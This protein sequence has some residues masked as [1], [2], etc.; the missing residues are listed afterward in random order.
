MALLAFGVLRLCPPLCAFVL[1]SVLLVAALSAQVA[2]RP[3]E[4]GVYV[5]LDDHNDAAQ[6]RID[7][8]QQARQTI[9]IEYFIAEA[10]RISLG[11]LVLL[12]DAAR[13]GVRVRILLD[14]S[15][16]RL[17]RRLQGYMV[18]QGIEI[19]EYHPFR[20]WKPTW[21]TRRLHDK[22]ILVDGEASFG[23]LIAGGRN[24]SEPYFGLLGRLPRTY[25]D[26]DV[27]V[28]GPAV[29][30]ANDYF[31]QLWNSSEVSP[32]RL[33]DFDPSV[34]DRDCGEEVGGLRRRQ[35]WQRQAGLAE[36]MKE[37]E[38]LLDRTRAQ[39]GQSLLVRFDTGHD[40]A[41]GRRQVAG[42]RFLHDPVGK[43]GLARGIGQEL[44]DL[45]DSAQR[46]VVIESPYLVPSR[47][48]RRV[49]R[50][51][52]D[53]GVRVRI[54]TN[55]LLTTDNLFP[56]AG[57]QSVKRRL[58]RWGIELWEYT[59]PESLHSKSAVID[60]RIAVVGSYN[61]D[62]RS[63]HL[64]TEL[65]L[66]VEDEVIAAELQ[67][68][69]DRHLQRAWKI[70]DRGYPEGHDRKLPGVGWWKRLKLRLLRLVAPLIKRQ[71]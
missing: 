43:K 32:T 13:R 36:A 38:E 67:Q 66:V 25:V 55:S 33:G 37:A 9:D 35:C 50:R 46:S 30:A 22:M 48:F 23:S 34:R 4:V 64:N 49:L 31:E 17:T 54:L 27:F 10:D 41:Q 62:P 61:L 18:S 53:R 39:L 70:D 58:R 68:S 20:P 40:W 47:S 7:A 15:F 42:I 63:E 52:R 51:A 44:L 69:M 5:L 14:A 6:A 29:A 24:A 12:R 45:F 65:A 60:D 16:N 26:R 1:Q 3:D 21:V 59:G 8:I 11:G 56:Q 28:T 2:D 57:Y 19:R 71:L